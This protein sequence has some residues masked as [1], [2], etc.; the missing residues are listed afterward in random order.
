MAQTGSAA[1]D[2]RSFLLM[3]VAMPAAGALAVGTIVFVGY[4]MAAREPLEAADVGGAAIFGGA[5]LLVVWIAFCAA[6]ARVRRGGGSGEI[7]PL[8][9]KLTPLLILLGAA[10]GGWAGYDICRSHQR[11][12]RE[13]AEYLCTRLLA[14]PKTDAR[15]CRCAPLALTCEREQRQ[16]KKED[17]RSPQFH[18]D[19]RGR[20]EVRAPRTNSRHRLRGGTRAELAAL[21][22]PSTIDA[23]R[24]RGRRRAL[25]APCRTA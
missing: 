19:F 24:R 9:A 8:L 21:D 14:A 22:P 11:D 15:W 2:V 7:F 16:H 4:Q 6:A 10:G 1:N 12:L 20:P 18:P 17:L 3:L 23:I 25:W 5:S 13:S